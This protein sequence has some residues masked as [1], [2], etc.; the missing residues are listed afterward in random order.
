MVAA[1]ISA[2]VPR[3]RR[4]GVTMQPEARLLNCGTAYQGSLRNSYGVRMA[5]MAKTRPMTLDESV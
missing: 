5:A 1:R 4:G 3:V 2:V